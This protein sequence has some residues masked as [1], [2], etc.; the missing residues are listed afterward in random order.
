MLQQ[1]FPSVSHPHQ[2]SFITFKFELHFHADN[3]GSFLQETEEIPLAMQLR[4]FPFIDLKKQNKLESPYHQRGKFTCSALWEDTTGL[5]QSRGGS[6]CCR[7]ATSS[8]FQYSALPIGLTLTAARIILLAWHRETNETSQ[9]IWQA[10]ITTSMDGTVA[11]RGW[12]VC[13]RA[14]T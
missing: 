11:R 10:A 13:L 3:L 12:I 6:G 9:H 1:S 5:S 2:I 4:K 14:C 7:A 8:L